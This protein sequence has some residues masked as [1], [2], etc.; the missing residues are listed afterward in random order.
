MSVTL[1]PTIFMAPVMIRTVKILIVI[2]KHVIISDDAME[3]ISVLP[4]P[5]NHEIH[6]IVIMLV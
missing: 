1:S 3:V 2:F 5:V 6:H 4:M